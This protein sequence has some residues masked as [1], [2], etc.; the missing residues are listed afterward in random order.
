MRRFL[1]QFLA[2]ILAGLIIASGLLYVSVELTSNNPIKERIYFKVPDKQNLNLEAGVY[3]VF[4]EYI[5]HKGEIG[6]IEFSKYEK[7]NGV[8]SLLDFRI[9]NTAA[10]TEVTKAED[11]S[12]SYSINDVKGESL[13]RFQINTTNQYA[14]TTQFRNT[15]SITLIKLT[16]IRNLNEF[17]ISLFKVMG[18][19]VLIS[20]PFLLLGWYCYTKEE[21]RKK[22]KVDDSFPE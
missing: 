11:S 6:P 14:I 10:N 22:V 8:S 21:K 17:I 4:Y 5:I 13:Y 20:L 19:I 1:R 16:I 7:I 15:E 3:T 12:L 2:L 9:I 18:I